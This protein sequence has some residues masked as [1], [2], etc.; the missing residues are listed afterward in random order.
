MS[1]Q[2]TEIDTKQ[3]VVSTFVGVNV[4]DMQLNQK[5]VEDLE[6]EQPLIKFFRAH[7]TKIDGIG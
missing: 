1:S 7:I 6:K 5:E 2:E 3:E 4:Q